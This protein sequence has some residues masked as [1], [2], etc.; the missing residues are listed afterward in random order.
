MANAPK[1]GKRLAG[2]KPAMNFPNT[3]SGQFTYTGATPNNQS[4]D[5]ALID[6]ILRSIAGVDFNVTAAPA[7]TLSE[8]PK[9][10]ALPRSRM[11]PN[12]AAA[13]AAAAAAQ[14]ESA[15]PVRPAAQPRSNPQG[16]PNLNNR[17][18]AAY[19]RTGGNEY[20]AAAS[21]YARQQAQPEEP[22]QGMRDV[23]Q[24]QVFRPARP[25]RRDTDRLPTLVD[26]APRRKH[27]VLNRLLTLIVVVLILV[28]LVLG[29]KMVYILG[30]SM[31]WN[32]PDLSNVPVIS[33]VLGMI[34]DAEEQP[35]TM[36]EETQ[37]GVETIEN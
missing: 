5:D 29:V 12:Q 17:G 19:A 2:N 18:A 8:P 16:M 35:I 6:E 27:P 21:T 31:G 20:Q 23:S 32:L 22:V 14:P 33:Q 15:A 26:E 13:Q 4:V 9:R 24:T 28:A 30:P 25:A 7:R 11:D 36:P 1:G 34:P 10:S 3:N 37:S